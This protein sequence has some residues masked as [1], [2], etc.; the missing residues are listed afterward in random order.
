MNGTDAYEFH[1]KFDAGV[2]DHFLV[3]L[4][5]KHGY[6]NRLTTI[7]KKE[8]GTDDGSE[9]FNAFCEEF[10]IPTQLIII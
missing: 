6:K 2:A 10:E 8:F 3:Q 7:L 5:M 9:L 1:Y 4:R